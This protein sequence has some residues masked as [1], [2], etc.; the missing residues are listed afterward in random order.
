M[1][2]TSATETA[3][4]M[5][6]NSAIVGSVTYLWTKSLRWVAEYTYTKAE[7]QTARRRRRTRA[8]SA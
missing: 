2:T 6:K 3:P 8:P 5:K 1:T 4:F 7:A